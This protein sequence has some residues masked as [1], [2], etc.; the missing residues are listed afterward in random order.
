MLHKI[1]QI[2]LHISNEIDD[3]MNI[4]STNLHFKSVT[5]RSMVAKKI[6]LI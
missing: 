5:P 2:E 4:D 6:R 1:K 3:E